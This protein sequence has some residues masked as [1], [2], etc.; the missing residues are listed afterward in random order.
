LFAAITLS[1]GTAALAAQ[2]I[3]FNI[4]TFSFMPAFAFG[5]GATTLVGQN[6]GAHDP[7][8]AAASAVQAWKSGLAWMCLMGLGFLVFRRPLV[9]LYTDDPTVIQLA[10]VLMLFLVAGQPLQATSIVLGSAL[11]GAGDT[12]VVMFITMAGVWFMRL[13][14]GYLVGIAFGLGLFGVWVGWMADFIVRALLVT[15]R[16]RSGRWKQI[17]V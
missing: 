9:A 14:V 8:R 6:L 15:W 4:A 2:Q 7:Q 17:N 3:V 5:I 11:R 13:G 1:L 12:R 10:S 16:Y